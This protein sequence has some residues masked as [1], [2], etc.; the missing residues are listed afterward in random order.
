MR[1]NRSAVVLISA[2]ASLLLLATPALAHVT[3][4]GPG[5]TQGG[6]TKLTFRVPTERDVA[7][8]KLEVQFPADAPLASASVKPHAGWTA[9]H[10]EGQAGHP[11]QGRRRQ[12]HRRGRL[13]DHLDRH[14][15]RH[16]AG[17]VR[18][19]RGLC[20]PAAQGRRDGLQGAADLQ[21]RRGRPLDRDRRRPRA[22]GPDP[23]T[24]AGRRLRHPDRQCECQPGPHCQRVGR[25]GGQ[26]RAQ[27]RRARPSPCSPCSW[28]SVPSCG[29]A[30]ARPRDIRR[31]APRSWLPCCC[32][33]GWPLRPAPTPRCCGPPPATPRSSS[34]GPP[35]VT[36]T[37]GEPVGIGLGNL[38]VVTADGDR[39]DTARPP[40]PT[41][42]RSCTSRCKP[43]LADGTY[44]VVWRVV[45]ADSH[46]VSGRVHVQRRRPSVD[47]KE[48]LGRGNL[49]S[50]SPRRR[51]ARASRSG[52]PGSSGSRPCRAARWRVLLPAALAGRHCPPAPAAARRRC[53]SSAR[54]RRGTA[55][56]RRRTRP[57]AALSKCLRQLPAARTSST[58]STA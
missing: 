30:A 45:C 32:S 16:Q 6:Y 14:R 20:R 48:L 21:G 5:A 56:A 11:A 24:G 41:A 17:R 57:A 39:V 31:G 47:P 8:T 12:H 55:A 51:A 46:P 43:A 52:S 53:A 9:R 42:A 33:S 13:H 58:A 26:R 4:Q 22:P 37:F 15:R 3:V 19:V 28:A 1:I 34:A 49:T 29:A 35:E 38:R 23:E 7:T 25:R 10:Q 18:R 50:L 2:A 40:A 54:R 44:L 27:L 36:L